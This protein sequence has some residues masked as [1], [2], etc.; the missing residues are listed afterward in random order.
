VEPDTPASTRKRVKKTLIRIAEE[1]ETREISGSES[2]EGEGAG[3]QSEEEAEAGPVLKG[4]PATPRTPARRGRRGVA[5]RALDTANLAESYFEAQATKVL[6]SDRTLAKL[7]TPRLSA[8]EVASLIG[9][10]EVQYGAEIKELL[11]DHAVQ[12]PKWHS[13]LHRG[14]NNVTYGLG[15]KKSLLHDFHSAHLADCDTVVVNGFFPSLTLKSIL[16]TIAED[17][18]ELEG[19]AAGPAELLAEV[20][21]AMDEEDDPVYLIVHNIDGVMLRSEKCQEALAALAGHPRIHLICS[22]D[23]INAPLIWD[24]RRLSKLNF[25]WF[26]C[27]TFLPYR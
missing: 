11:A 10:N 17:V 18:L 8:T 20:L 6:T 9:D 15:S 5:A 3:S 14:Y 24:Q 23:H 13:L 19:S 21:A 2:E 1:I 25:I 22:I 27:T 12:F 16:S 26:D 7:A 4:P